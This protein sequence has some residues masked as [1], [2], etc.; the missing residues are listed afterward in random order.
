MPGLLFIVEEGQAQRVPQKLPLL[1]NLLPKSTVGS[2]FPSAGTETAVLNDA[3]LI[4]CQNPRLVW[5]SDVPDSN[6]SWGWSGA[7]TAYPS[8]RKKIKE[9]L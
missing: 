8:Y 5:P 6:A 4:H 1:R 3:P 7:R 2:A 9:H